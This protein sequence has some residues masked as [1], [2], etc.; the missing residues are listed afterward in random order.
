MSM[1]NARL[2]VDISIIIIIKEEDFLLLSKKGLRL[3]AGGKAKRNNPARL[4]K[5]LRKSM[6]SISSSKR[7]GTYKIHKY[8]ADCESTINTGNRQQEEELPDNIPRAR[9][10]SDR[11]RQLLECVCV[12]EGRAC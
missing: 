12:G 9:F 11:L 10:Y 6:I 3:T 8:N 7:G 1:R 2:K 5:W 4:R